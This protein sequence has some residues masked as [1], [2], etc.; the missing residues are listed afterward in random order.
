MTPVPRSS[1]PAS[2]RR[3]S[4]ECRRLRKFIEMPP[5][6]VPAP[7]TPTRLMSRGSTSSGQALDLGRLALGK[8]EI[9]LRLGLRPAHQLH[10]HLALV[11]HAFGI[12]ASG[13]R[14]G[15]PR[16]WL[17][18]ASKPRILRPLA[19]RNS[20]NTAGSLL[21][22]CPAARMI[23]GSGRMSL[24]FLGEGDRMRD[25]SS[26]STSRSMTPASQARWRRSGRRRRTSPAPAGLRRRA[27]AAGCRRRRAAGPA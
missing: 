1:A 5:P 4:R 11:E 26:P 6:M 21:R 16:R 19:L 18:G 9:L 27:A 24:H 3:W 15:P 10:E 22:P 7:I 2:S 12:R 13:S 23:S 8:E 25:S 17:R 14:S 20:S